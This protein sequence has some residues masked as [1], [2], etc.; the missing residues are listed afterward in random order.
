V[1]TQDTARMIASATD[2]A[3]MVDSRLGEGIRARGSRW[4]VNPLVM[5]QDGHGSLIQRECM[6]GSKAIIQ[7]RLGPSCP[8]S[9]LFGNAVQFA[10][11]KN[12]STVVEIGLLPFDPD[13]EH[14]R[15][16]Q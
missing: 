13:R 6:H 4:N 1:E 12:S 15:C 5:N 10:D 8:C 11:Q 9:E 2:P 16:H 14:M 3:T 7:N